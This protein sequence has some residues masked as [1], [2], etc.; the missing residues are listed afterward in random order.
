MT[1]KARA[2]H[3]SFHMKKTRQPN[4]TADLTNVRLPDREAMKS[5]KLSASRKRSARVPISEKTAQLDEF[6]HAEI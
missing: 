4:E 6:H 3:V 5:R 1:V 2:M